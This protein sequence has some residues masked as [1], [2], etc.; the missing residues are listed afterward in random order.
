MTSYLTTNDAASVLGKTPDHIGKLCRTGKIA[1][2]AIK[3]GQ[4]LVPKN[5]DPKL[6][7][8]TR[9]EVEEVEAV[10]REVGAPKVDEA[11]RRLGLLKKM[12]NFVNNYLNNSDFRGGRTEAVAAFAVN[13]NASPATLNRWVARFKEHGLRGLVDGRGRPAGQ[14]SPIH[15]KAWQT[16][17][18]YYLDPRQ[19]KVKQC[20]NILTYLN[21]RDNRGWQIPS[22][23]T[24]YGLI[25]EIP[26]GVKVLHREGSRAYESKCSPYIIQDPDSVEP[27]EVWV[28]DH[29][30]FNCWVRYRNQWICPWI[31]SGQD[32]RSRAIF[33]HSVNAGPNQTTILR[34]F[35][36]GAEAHGVPDA[37]KVD[38]GKDYASE[39]WVGATKQKRREL[40]KGYLDEQLVA[41]I[42]ALLNIEVSFAIPYNAKAK[43][44]ERFFDTMD[45]QFIKTIPTYCGKDTKRRPEN[46]NL[47]SRKTIAEAY[48]LEEFAE[49]VEE[50]I[51]TVYNRKAHTGEGMEGRSPLEV[52][53]TREIEQV[54]EPEQLDLLCRVWSG[55]LTVGKNGVRFRG[56][57]YGQYDHT[58]LAM[59]GKK[60]RV[61][62]DP[63]DLSEVDVYD[64]KYKYITTAGQAKL[65]AY[66]AKVSDEDLREGMKQQRRAKKIAKEY[67]KNG[68]VR[69]LEPEALAV[70]AHQER[71]V[72]QVKPF[73][74]RVVKT[75]KAAASEAAAAKKQKAKKLKKAVGQEPLDF[76]F[77]QL[78]GQKNAIEDWLRGT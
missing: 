34:A 56:L 70:K 49:I 67:R 50:W 2:A 55:E 52:F 1:G 71:T 39:M 28:G 11:L 61:S 6:M 38:N 17:L 62:Y 18:H 46:L 26:Q 78:K 69:H 58:L 40:K 27:G 31:T 10:R 13:N 36:R 45:Q 20:Y 3:G 63:D 4:W 25:K 33:G 29:S 75:A 59:Q 72:P 22:L 21:A 43:R 35:K 16:F 37:V 5:C 19:P 65:M 60:V 66:G 23:S 47:D 42:Y 76:D 32:L 24:I 77:S 68:L 14:L 44:I 15:P 73:K 48:S 9:D 7:A 12:E 64:L 8:V 51:E 54:L 53:N 30:Q 41:G 57:W 74:P